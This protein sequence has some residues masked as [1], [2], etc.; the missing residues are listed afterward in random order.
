LESEPKAVENGT[1]G[2]ID[3]LRIIPE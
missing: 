3:L 2:V 1:K